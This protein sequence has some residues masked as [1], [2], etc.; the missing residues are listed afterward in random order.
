MNFPEEQNV[1]HMNI[2]TKRIFIEECKKFLMSSLL[3][4]KETKWDK[5]LF[6]SRVRAWASVS[7]LMDTSNQKTDLCE[8]FLFWEYITETLESISL[9]SPEEVEQAKENISILIC[10]IHDVPVTASALFY[11]TRIMKLDQEGST[12]LSGQL[13]P[14]VSEMT[15]LYDDITQFA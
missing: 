8:S 2:T 11:L 9:Y 4:I 13:H 14:L 7:G 6:S 15:R 10:S 12:S 1:Q 3:H 5:D